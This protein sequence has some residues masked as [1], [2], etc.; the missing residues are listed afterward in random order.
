M[1][2]VKFWLN[3][4]HEIEAGLTILRPMANRD[5]TEGKGL[6]VFK[7]IPNIIKYKRSFSSLCAA[8]NIVE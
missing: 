1:V 8:V 4:Q 6:F 7:Q 2:Q 5:D 3:R